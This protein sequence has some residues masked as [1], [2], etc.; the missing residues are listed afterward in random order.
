MPIEIQECELHTSTHV[1]DFTVV[2][3]GISYSG[4]LIHKVND[5]GNFP[6]DISKE[7][8]WDKPPYSLVYNKADLI[9]QLFEFMSEA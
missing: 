1:Y 7:I 8:Q 2:Y 5:S 3:Y 4:K 6:V 9:D